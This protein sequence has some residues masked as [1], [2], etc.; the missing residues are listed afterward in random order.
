MVF[1]K[2]RPSLIA[3][4]GSELADANVNISFLYVCDMSVRLWFIAVACR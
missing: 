3:A 4:V 2:V 1:Q